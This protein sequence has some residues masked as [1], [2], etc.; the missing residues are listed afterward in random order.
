MVPVVTDVNKNGKFDKDL[1]SW[2]FEAMRKI[3]LTGQITDA[4]AD[5]VRAKLEYLDAK[6]T[7]DI[8]IYI[9]SPGGSVTA[10]LSIMDAM[11]NCKSDIRTVCTGIAASMG[12]FLISCGTKGKRGIERHAE[13]MI[14]QPLGGAYGQASD[15]ELMAEH[16]CKVKRT[17][18]TILANNT[19]KPIQQII[20][21]T[22]RDNYL[23]AE[24]AVEYGLVDKI[25]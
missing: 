22:D 14:H 25:I 11:N 19:G 8:I 15:V 7:G 10:G 18:N 21:D 9:N 24:E 16:M 17:L 3:R 13:M 2:E 1:F 12:A 6:G 23:S 5:E 20:V 4:V